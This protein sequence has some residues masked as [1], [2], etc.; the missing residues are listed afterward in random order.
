MKKFLKIS[1]FLLLLIFIPYGCQK[2]NEDIVNATEEQIA[3]EGVSIE[4]GMVTFKS[5][6]DFIRTIQ[7]LRNTEISKNSIDYNELFPSFISSAEAFDALTEDDVI[8]EGGDIAKFQD[9]AIFIEKEDGDMYL[10]A[11]V[12]SKILGQIVNKNG[13]YKVGDKVIKATYDF[14][15]EIEAADYFNGI[16]I[17]QIK[18]VAK[19]YQIV[20]N[21]TFLE[22]YTTWGYCSKVY[23]HKKRK[24]Y[25]KME[26]RFITRNSPLWHYTEARVRTTNYKRGAFGGWY[27]EYAYKIHHSGSGSYQRLLP[28][29]FGNFA[30][31]DP[32]SFTFDQTAWNKK[33]LDQLIVEVEFNRALRYVLGSNS[34]THEV[35]KDNNSYGPATCYISF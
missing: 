18:S 10:E 17:E 5:K 12:D 2:S 11:V 32:V 26:G 30:W 15:Y 1:L 25:R 24:Q 8:A 22:K 14:D 28:D 20:R 35:N 19:K 33:E 23:Q 29:I 6:D 27:K 4:G 21:E 3:M 7:Y 34:G 9:Y 31:A 16:S 13:F